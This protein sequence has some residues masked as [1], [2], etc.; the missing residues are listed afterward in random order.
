VRGGVLKE[1]EKRQVNKLKGYGYQKKQKNSIPKTEKI[2]T[3]KRLLPEQINE[4]KE[5]INTGVPSSEIAD[6]FSVSIQTIY[7]LKS[8]MKKQKEDSVYKD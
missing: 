6:Q 3:R 4:M 8:K 7:L 5:M 2:G 1:K